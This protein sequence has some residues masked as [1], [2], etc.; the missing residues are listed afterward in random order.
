MKKSLGIFAAAFV[1]LGMLFFTGCLDDIG[2]GLHDCGSDMDCFESY[3][4]NCT[5]AKV[6]NVTESEGMTIAIRAQIRSGTLEECTSWVILD[7]ITL[8]IPSATQQHQ[9][10]I[11][12]MKQM[13]EGKDMTC[14]GP[15]SREIGEL[16]GQT[17]NCSGPLFDAIAQ[18]FGTFDT[19]ASGWD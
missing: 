7:T 18:F 1:V 13:L 10:A 19:S 17:G 15:A 3:A 6:G 5:P 16:T 9:Q 4:E 2:A 8:D 12:F 14:V 11:A